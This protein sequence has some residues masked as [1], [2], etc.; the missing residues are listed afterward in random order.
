MTLPSVL[1]KTF[2]FSLRLSLGRS[3]DSPLEID[4]FCYLKNAL[5]VAPRAQRWPTNKRTAL[6]RLRAGLDAASWETVN[7]GRATHRLIL[8]T[9]NRCSGVEDIQSILGIH[10][11]SRTARKD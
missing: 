8:G 4:L 5:E 11:E 9:K 3:K 6:L 1:R 10:W 2:I 7:R